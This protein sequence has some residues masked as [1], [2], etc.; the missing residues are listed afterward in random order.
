[1]TYYLSDF[2]LQEISK[3]PPELAA[4]KDQYPVAISLVAEYYD[5]PPFPQGYEPKL[6]EIYFGEHVDGPGIL[7]RKEKGFSF[8]SDFYTLNSSDFFMDIDHQVGYVRLGSQVLL[9]RVE[10]VVLPDIP[11]ETEINMSAVK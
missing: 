1:M 6:I 9:N 3:L 10:G 8:D 2:Q 7:Y 11:S 4:L 5:A